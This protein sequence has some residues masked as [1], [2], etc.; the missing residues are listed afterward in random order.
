V[1]LLL[2]L[3]LALLFFL[4][5]WVLLVP[6]ALWQR[7][8]LG[9]ARRR[10]VPWLVG[11]N[12]WLLLLSTAVFVCSAWFVGF[13]VDS[14]LSFSFAGLGV[15]AVVGLVGLA[16][17]RFE[18]E[19]GAQ[20][21]T[22]NRWLVLAL[23]LIVAARIGYGVWRAWHAWQADSSALWLAQQGSVLAVGGLV[24]GYYLA[25]GWGLRHRLR[26]PGR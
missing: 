4:L 23:T 21:Y 2:L 1:P 11:L 26:Q 24:L 12:A 8:R 9:K 17:T 10:V 22:A 15:G 25:Y 14:A 3:P 6:V 18:H 20:F 16:M 19:G 7:Y 5:L 13:W